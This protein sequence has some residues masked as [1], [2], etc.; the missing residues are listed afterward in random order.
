MFQL[1]INAEVSE[2]SHCITSKSKKPIC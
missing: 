1:G 2:S